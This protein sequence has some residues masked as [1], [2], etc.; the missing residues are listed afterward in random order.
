VTWLTGRR[1]MLLVHRSLIVEKVELQ[2]DPLPMES[3]WKAVKWS[4]MLKRMPRGGIHGF[5][6]A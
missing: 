4:R 2:H 5:V 3:P 6:A 1:G